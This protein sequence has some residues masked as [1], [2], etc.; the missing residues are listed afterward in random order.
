[1]KYENAFDKLK[2]PDN[3]EDYSIKS[4]DEK[5]TVF[6]AKNSA[7]N[8]GIVIDFSNW[9]GAWPKPRRT[10][11]IHFL[12]DRGANLSHINKGKI[13]RIVGIFLLDNEVREPFTIFI[14]ALM[15]N[16]KCLDDPNL[17]WEFLEDFYNCFSDKRKDISREK[18]IGMWG[19]IYF[20]LNSDNE[21]MF[22]SWKGPEDYEFDFAAEKIAM[23][24]KTTTSELRKHRVRHQQVQ[25]RK[26]IETFI[27]SL[28]IKHSYSGGKSVDDLVDSMCNKLGKRALEF[29]V[30]L[31]RLGYVCR[32]AHSECIKKY[33]LRESAEGYYSVLDLP[34]IPIDQIPEAIQR[35]E[36]DIVLTN[37]AKINEAKIS[38]ILNNLANCD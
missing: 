5:G 26:D 4:I 16:R 18:A 17:L 21:K 25:P 15:K 30:K 22:D 34:N 32:G 6:I 31:R 20:L 12:S 9:K 1:M 33:S 35:L 8:I 24:V 14:E 37:I 11:S 10:Y 19:E 36:F 2:K 27:Y 38:Y 3:S 29:R 23:D 13:A 7:D 28:K